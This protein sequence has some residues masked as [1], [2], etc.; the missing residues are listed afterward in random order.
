MSDKSYQ[1][2]CGAIVQNEKNSIFH[3]KGICHMN[4][5]VDVF[6]MAEEIKLLRRKFKIVRDIAIEISHAYENNTPKY[7]GGCLTIDEQ[8]SRRLKEED[9]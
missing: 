4:D 8:L 6:A 9:K 7:A 5:G 3:K 2:K 1:C